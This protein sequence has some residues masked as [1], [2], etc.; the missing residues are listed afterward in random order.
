MQ[1]QASEDDNDVAS[2][3]IHVNDKLTASVAQ[4][5]YTVDGLRGQTLYA[6]KVRA[7]DSADKSVATLS[8]RTGGQDTTPPTMP[9]GLK[10]EVVTQ[11]SVLLDWDPSQDN[12]AVSGFTVT[13]A[14]G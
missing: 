12:V 9:G 3:Q 5:R 4:L 14:V 2:Y 8:V 13:T 11:N 10:A 1:W 7:V 6:F